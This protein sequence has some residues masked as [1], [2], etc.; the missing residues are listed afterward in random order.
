M[1]NYYILKKKETNIFEAIFLIIVGII[2]AFFYFKYI[3]LET[4]LSAFFP[5]FIISLFLPNIHKTN[6]ILLRDGL[7]V[8]T[9]FLAIGFWVFGFSVPYINIVLSDGKMV[10]IGSIFYAYLTFK[11][12]QNN[13]S[14]FKYQR[15]PNI[16]IKTKK[17]DASYTFLIVNNSRYPVKNV[18]VAFHIVYPIPEDRYF[19]LMKW[20]LNHQYDFLIRKKPQNSTLKSIS[21]IESNE[22]KKITLDDKLYSLFDITKA[23]TGYGVYEYSN[24][25]TDCKRF[26]IITDLRYSSQDNL[27]IE[28]PIFKKFEFEMDSK[29]IKLIHDSDDPRTIF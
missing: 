12:L 2:L 29:G 18:K 21:F 3:S 16:T 4:V 6:Q 20:F 8:L 25:P 10:V 19:V 13:S 17:E 9:F 15:M 1:V 27:E 7:I 24:L 22:T 23:L 14:I 26:D 11:N 5:L 28:N